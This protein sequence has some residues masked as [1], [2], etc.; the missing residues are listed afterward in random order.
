MCAKM[1][2]GGVIRRNTNF[3]HWR[4]AFSRA[5]C[6]DWA[7]VRLICARV[8]FEPD[9]RVQL[10]EFAFC[11]SER[12][13]LMYFDLGAAGNEVGEL[14]WHVG[15]FW[16]AIWMVFGVGVEGGGGWAFR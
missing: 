9:C 1:S 8:S 14:V 13:L 5:R 12:A 10:K 11:R 3:L 4:M 15:F 2:L 6:C 16:G 7:R